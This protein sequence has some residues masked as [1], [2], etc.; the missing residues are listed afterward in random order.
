[1]RHY[2]VTLPSIGN[3]AMAAEN[4]T[5][6]DGSPEAAQTPMSFSMYEHYGKNRLYSLAFAAPAVYTTYDEIKVNPTAADLT[7]AG[8]GAHNFLNAN[9]AAEA[10]AVVEAAKSGCEFVETS[11]E[12]NRTDLHSYKDHPWSSE[13]DEEAFREYA[14][15]P[16]LYTDAAVTEEGGRVARDPGGDHFHVGP[17]K[18]SQA[19]GMSNGHQHVTFKAEASACFPTAGSACGNPHLYIS[20]SLHLKV[21]TDPFQCEAGG[22]ASIGIKATVFGVD[23]AFEASCGILFMPVLGPTG[24]G[25]EM[26][27][28]AGRKLSI[29]IASVQAKIGVSWNPPWRVVNIRAPNGAFA[30][31]EVCIGWS[32]GSLSVPIRLPV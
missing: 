5:I 20:A 29:A 17:I 32:C 4:V 14:S 10:L 27:L 28:W 3:D 7:A 18:F 21:S 23:C 26:V 24:I 12:F 30:E 19:W 15:L 25:W 11:L 9:T 31:V 1:V 6:G 16:P 2:K 13:A 8:L 22:T